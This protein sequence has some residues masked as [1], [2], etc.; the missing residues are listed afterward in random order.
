MAERTEE[1]LA[2]ALRAAADLAPEPPA[3]LVLSVAVRRRR[4]RRRRLQ[5]ALAVTGVV[6][7]IGTGMTVMKGAF[8]Q[9]HDEAAA[10]PI[11]SASVTATPMATQQTFTPAA[12][13]WP[14]AVFRMP[15]KAR[16]GFAYRPVTALGPTEVLLSAE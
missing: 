1:Q 15:A 14:D 8:V 13:V 5:T 4:R 6:A 9:R 2:R 10:E 7:V 16:D 11:A 3:D 12:R